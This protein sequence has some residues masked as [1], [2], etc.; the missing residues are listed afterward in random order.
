MTLAEKI[1]F[2]E[3]GGGDYVENVIGGLPALCIPPLTLVDGPNGLA[4]GLRQVT[5]LPAS[6]A[7]AATFDRYLAYDYGQVIGGEARAKAFDVVQAPELNLAQVAQS[8]R[9]FEAFGEDPLLTSVMGVADAEGIQSRGVMAMAKHFT[10]YNQE[11]SRDAL[12]EVVS[13]RALQEL[14][15][16][17]FEAA[18]TA[19]RVAGVMCAAG[20]VNG[21]NDCSDPSL[22]QQLRSWGFTGFV[23]SDLGAVE[24]PAAAFQAGL[25]MIKPAMTAVITQLVN[26]DSISLDTLDDAVAGVLTEMFAFGL[27]SHPRTPDVAVPA[28][29]PADTLTALRV[30]ERSAVLLKN[31]NGLLP[32]ASS[33]GSVAVIGADAQ[34]QAMTAGG[35]SSHVNAPFL[36]TPLQA[37]Q[38]AFAKG[39]TI[40]A[41]LGGPAGN[42]LPAIPPGDFVSGGPLPVETLTQGAGESSWKAVIQVPQSGLYEFSLEHGGETWFSVNGRT[43]LAFPGQ[44]ARSTW[45][46]TIEL[47]AGLPYTLLVQWFATQDGLGPQLGLQ[48][49]SPLINQAVRVA[50]ASNVALVFVSD[51]ESEG[52]DRPSLDLPGDANSLIDAV[53]RANP[54]TVVVLNTGGAVLMPWLSDVQAVLEAWY[55]G[56]EDGAAVAD[57]LLG[58]MDPSGRLPVTFP[59]TDAAAQAAA[60]DGFPG[61]D[62]IVR[63]AS[64]LDIG[65][66]WYQA[67]EVT[68]LFPFGYGLSYTSF[69]L[70][71][72]SLQRTDDGDLARLTVTN[73]GKRDGT[74]VV[75][76]YVS[77]PGSAGEPKLQLAGFQTV[78][79]APGASTQITLKL[80]LRVFEAFLGGR[81]RTVPG[82][83]RLG[84]GQSSASVS[85]WLSTTQSAMAVPAAK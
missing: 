34:A 39:T 77:F 43:L 15:D 71:G 78:S 64:G 51:I 9:T 72:V 58:R 56:E 67:H 65:Y 32:L 14:Y 29:A 50:R 40:R 12:D 44:R 61:V 5:Q 25:D 63:Y 45:S 84:F 21:V 52:S 74:D 4:A 20:A 53:A 81:F 1:G 80:P 26:D 24:K 27:I 55:P 76:A 49:V 8:G 31:A 68:P 18:V 2:V 82:L 23:R 66:R 3:L 42:T 6:I 30:A 75:Q 60:G 35:G 11:T 69:T 7:L 28:V 19:A 59:A 38:N 70:S 79:L 48:D 37:L 17:P 73:T 16:R 13:Q 46:T 10:A 83:Y 57:I 47:R 41:A 62:D 22:Y 54:H 33:P 36:I 85:L